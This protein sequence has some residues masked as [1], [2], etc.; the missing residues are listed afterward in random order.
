[1]SHVAVTASHDTTVFSDLG[2]FYFAVYL[3]FFFSVVILQSFVFLHPAKK[4]NDEKNKL[5]RN[6]A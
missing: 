1:M 5:E 4:I 3:L 6:V 2:L